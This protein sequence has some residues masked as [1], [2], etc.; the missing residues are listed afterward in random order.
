MSLL[1][2]F[3]KQVEVMATLL[4]R[5]PMGYTKSVQIKVFEELIIPDSDPL[6]TQQVE[7]QD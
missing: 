2:T 6:E 3:R 5:S 4:V 7:V 1:R